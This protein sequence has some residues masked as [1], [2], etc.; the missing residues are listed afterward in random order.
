MSQKKKKE[1]EEKKEGINIDLGFGELFKGLGNII[2]LATKMAEE[3]KSVITK[4]GE[5][6][7]LGEKAKG[8]F[9]I[10]VRTLAGGETTVEPFGNIHKVTEKGP[11]VEEVREP[12]IDVFE[13]PDYVR[14]VAELPG[15]EE[16]DI[17]YELKKD[18][19]LAITSLNADRKYSKEVSLPCSIDPEKVESKYKNGIL[20]LKLMKL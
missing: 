6:K 4:T 2:D 9:G 3:G 19:A 15:V 1:P 18:N 14:V 13:E 10:S 12:I 17:K 16:K 8:V 20:E 11:V 5:I 7:G